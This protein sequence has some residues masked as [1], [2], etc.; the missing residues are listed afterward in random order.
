MQRLK[1]ANIC[2]QGS[3]S[4][5]IN[6]AQQLPRTT[7]AMEGCHPGDKKAEHVEF[8]MGVHS[9]VLC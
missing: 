1:Q 2:D 6:Q 5:V 7:L 3:N 8:F 4:C 9:M